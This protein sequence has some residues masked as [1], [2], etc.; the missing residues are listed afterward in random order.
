[1]KVH[2][3]YPLDNESWLTPEEVV[4]HFRVEFSQVAFDA[5]TARE[6]GTVVLR[7][8]RALLD[9]G[10][11]NA[12]SLSIGDLKERWHG[13]LAIFV[14]TDDASK[15]SFHTIACHRDPLRL[16]FGHSVKGRR[17]KP[18]AVRAAKALGYTIQSLD[19]D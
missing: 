8:Y 2:Y 3:L 14:V 17:H 12:N 13:A 5:D 1:M 10:L 6:Q 11:G 4:D 15:E 18:I 16:D 9:A 19:G 7:K